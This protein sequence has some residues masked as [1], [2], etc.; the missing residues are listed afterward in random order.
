M[1]QIP[2]AAQVMCLKE[3]QFKTCNNRCVKRVSVCLQTIFFLHGLIG[4]SDGARLAPVT[5]YFPDY[6]CLYCFCDI[7][8]FV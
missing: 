6:Y 4:N 7:M 1:L 5:D 3:E 2:E 8:L